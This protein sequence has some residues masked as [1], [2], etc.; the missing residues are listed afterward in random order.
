MK[1]DI[2]IE[3]ASELFGIDK[4]KVTPE[5]RRFAKTILFCFR[6]NNE[7]GEEK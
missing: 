3:K 1:K 4:D 7:E 5:Q 2:Y 6:Y